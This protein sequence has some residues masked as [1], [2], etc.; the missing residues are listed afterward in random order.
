VAALID[1]SPNRHADELRASWQARAMANTDGYLN[2]VIKSVLAHNFDDA[3]PVLLTLV[4]GT[5]GLRLPGF[6][7]IAKINKDG[8][9]VADWATRSGEIEKNKVVFKSEE[10]M[11]GVFRKLADLMKLDDDDRVQM[12]IAVRKWCAADHR[13]DPTM[14]PNDPDAKRLTVH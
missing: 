9:I 8:Q 7:S 14:D 1:L 3:M 5:A 2:C 6:V 11:R 10:Q 4:Y 13:L 12:F